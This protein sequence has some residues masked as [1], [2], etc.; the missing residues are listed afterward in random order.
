MRTS[1]V[2]RNLVCIA[3][4]P[5]DALDLESFERELQLG[6]PTAQVSNEQLAL[7]EYGRLRVLVIEGRIQVDLQPNAAKDLVRGAA[8]EMIRQASLF[9]PTALGFNGVGRIDASASE[10]PFAGLIDTEAAMTRLGVVD[11]LPGLKLAYA[12]DDGRATLSIDPVLDDEGTWLAQ[13]NRHHAE[14]L[15]GDSLD[16]VIKWFVALDDDL[17]ALLRKLLSGPDTRVAGTDGEGDAHAA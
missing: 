4:M 15:S 1:F 3:S 10:E 9:R 14:M 13:L 16:D 8:S 2:G 7:A 17:P 11:A 6:R 5:P 12:L